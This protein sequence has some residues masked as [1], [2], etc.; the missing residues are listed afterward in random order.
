MSYDIENAVVNDVLCFVSTA[1]S[2]MPH[3]KVTL[4]AVA[5]YTEEDIKKA[6]D[7]VFEIAGDRPVNRRPCASH[8]NPSVADIGDILGLFEK[9]EQQKFLFPDFLARGYASIPPASGFEALAA[10]MCS[11]RDEL[12]NLKFEIAECR[13]A[14]QRDH[15]V[16]EDVRCVK[17][18]IMD[19]K[20]ILNEKVKK[21]TSAPTYAAVATGEASNDNLTGR[22]NSKASSDVNSAGSSILSKQTNCGDKAN[23]NVINAHSSQTNT[24]NV[25]R[26]GGNSGPLG[27]GNKKRGPPRPSARRSNIVGTKVDSTAR[28]SGVERV[29]DVFV[30]GC[31]LD[32]E[33]ADITEFCKAG[34]VVVKK[35][36]FLPT[37]SPWYTSFKVSLRQTDRDKVLDPD[38]WPCNIF[39]RKYFQGRKAN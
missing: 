16:L 7:V 24:A 13:S 17:A 36:E 22:Q 23:A 21:T 31:S 29:L 30:G 9:M 39:V 18:D 33:E 14:S 6:K 27:S 32:A 15:N 3:D 2:S 10:V 11:L 26:P 4:S 12:S 35:C 19:I 20:I 1:R 8:P 25:V 5:Y 37:K 28:I 38:F 34:G